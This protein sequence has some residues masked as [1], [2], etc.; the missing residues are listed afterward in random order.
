MDKETTIPKAKLNNYL[1]L[2]YANDSA[3]RIIMKLNVEFRDGVI[4]NAKSI[5]FKKSLWKESIILKKM[6]DMID[7]LKPVLKDTVFDFSLLGYIIFVTYK[8]YILRYKYKESPTPPERKSIIIDLDKPLESQCK[9]IYT[10]Y[11]DNPAA[12]ATSKDIDLVFRIRSAIL[13]YHGQ[14]GDESSGRSIGTGDSEQ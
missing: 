3:D 8:E 13:V 4:N 14:K 10:S 9:I 7:E 12:P 5:A 2:D 6:I 1:R 11:S